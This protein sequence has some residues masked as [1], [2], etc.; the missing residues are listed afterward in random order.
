MHLFVHFVGAGE[1]AVKLL[2]RGEI[3]WQQHESPGS[4]CCCYLSLSRLYR[5]RERGGACL[6]IA[7]VVT[8][9]QVNPSYCVSLPLPP[10][11]NGLWYDC[12]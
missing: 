2:D 6:T 7:I 4:R 1:G 8:G 11:R 9:I 3:V 5:D 12:Q 10:A